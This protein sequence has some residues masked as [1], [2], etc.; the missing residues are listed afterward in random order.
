MGYKIRLDS[1]G[2]W[3]Q[4][5]NEDA[6]R[7]ILYEGDIERQ[8]YMVVRRVWSLRMEENEQAKVEASNKEV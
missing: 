3:R 6:A 7:E 1:V 4:D 5:F 8:N 2:L